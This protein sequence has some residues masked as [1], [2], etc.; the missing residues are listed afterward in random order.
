MFTATSRPSPGAGWGASAHNISTTPADRPPG[1]P[2]S[3]GQIAT[4][5]FGAGPLTSRFFGNPESG[6]FDIANSSTHS[7]SNAHYFQPPTDLDFTLKQQSKPPSQQWQTAIRDLN[8]PRPNSLV[9]KTARNPS[10]GPEKP[11]GRHTALTD[12]EDAN[13]S[14]LVM[15]SPWMKHSAP[16]LRIRNQTGNPIPNEMDRHLSLSFPSISNS[17]QMQSTSPT[18]QFL[19]LQRSETTP[20]LI[21]QSPVRLVSPDTCV[22]ILES[23]SSETLLLDVRPQPQFS[24]SRIKGSLNLCIPTTLLKRPSFNLEKVEDTFGLEPERLKFKKWRSSTRIIVYDSSTSHLKDASLL[25]NLMKKFTREGWSGEALILKGGFAQFAPGFPNWVESPLPPKGTGMQGRKKPLSINLTLPTGGPSISGGCFIPSSTP[26]FNPFFT[27]IRQNV[28]LIDGVGQIPVRVPDY[29]NDQIKQKMPRWLAH[30]VDSAD[31]GKTVASQFFK[32]EK[33]EQ[34]RMQEALSDSSMY[35]SASSAPKK[36]A[37]RI[38]GIEMG[39]K[40]RYNN[41][42]PYDHC[43]V[44]LQEA[45]DCFGDYINASHVKSSR[46]NKSYIATQAPMPATF[47]DFWRAVWEQDVRLIVMLTAESEGAQVKCH[48]YWN[49]AKYGNLEV[50]LITENVIP[51]DSVDAKNGQG[52]NDVPCITVRHFGVTDSRAPFQAPR[53][54]TQVQYSDW[55]DFGAPAKPKHLMKLIEEC[56][57]ISN[58][59]NG[60]PTSQLEEPCPEHEHKVVIH[61]SAGCGRTGTF[62]TVDSVIDVLKRQKRE[63]KSFN[64]D[65]DL[66]AST[67]EEF[68][69]QRQS[70]VQCLRQFVLCYESVLEWFALDASQKH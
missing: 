68:R 62:C 24:Q 64:S 45:Q 37:I 5:F 40:N 21:D 29:M 25:T 8:T 1:T 27:N 10:D 18:A 61:C 13:I 34:H 42:Y 49:S 67:V 26:S 54:V 32:I 7:N 16:E 41:I 17:G 57:K 19:P 22:R 15:P 14:P 69:S 12:E 47:N 39:A 38:A 6:Y 66:V 53:E 65:D 31:A 55:P 60:K 51:L 70:M 11:S 30:A 23:S 20:A 63:E 48:R 56:N 9:I 43:R 36:Q 3:A 52:K 28:D 44:K 35:C 58:A 59:T 4:P 46:S 50:R 33:A 2:P